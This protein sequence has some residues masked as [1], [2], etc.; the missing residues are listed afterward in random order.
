MDRQCR[1]KTVL[2]GISTCA[3]HVG[4]CIGCYRLPL[5][6][7]KLTGSIKSFNLFPL[8]GD[9]ILRLG[10]ETSSRVSVGGHYWILTVLEAQRWDWLTRTDILPAVENMDRECTLTLATNKSLI[11]FPIICIYTIVSMH[12]SRWRKEYLTRQQ[13][14]A[15]FDDV[16]DF[17]VSR[18]SF[19]LLSV[20]WRGCWFAA[21]MKSVRP[22][23]Q[24]FVALR[25]N[26]NKQT[27]YFNVFVVIN[28]DL[29]TYFYSKHRN[30][31][32][33]ERP[34]TISVVQHQCC[35]VVLWDS[36]GLR[37]NNVNSS[38][39]LPT[40]MTRLFVALA[41][42]QKRVSFRTSA[43]TISLWRCPNCARAIIRQL[44]YGFIHGIVY[45]GLLQFAE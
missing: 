13:V 38:V 42:V 31:N 19:C 18:S 1:S 24:R 29:L 14:R 40:G 2:A 11:W 22:S 45:F 10:Q 17:A 44:S 4:S 33:L 5:F 3:N 12:L 37:L 9:D 20:D 32:V 34:S 25:V 16:I 23:L 26:I 7:G 21:I 28:S 30:A 35:R 8:Q 15:S 41:D 27:T 43:S 36:L 6:W 39:L